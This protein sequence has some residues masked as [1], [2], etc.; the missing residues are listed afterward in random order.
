[1]VLTELEKL[2]RKRIANK[3]WN[4]KNKE[5]YKQRYKKH[6]EKNTEYYIDKNKQYRENNKEKHK[7]YMKEY[8]ETPEG[9]K[10]QTKSNWK[11]YG[12]DMDTF[13][14]VYPIYLA[15]THCDRCNVLLEG[16][17][18]NKKCMDHCHATGMYRN[19]V[20]KKCNTKI[21]YI[22]Q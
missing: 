12:L 6:Y 13:Y 19:T 9:K 22:K 15:T 20:C 5:Y 4:D 3:K 8:N 10:A 18:N 21:A 17:G 14:Y 11:S 1:M 16:I 7:E 2:E